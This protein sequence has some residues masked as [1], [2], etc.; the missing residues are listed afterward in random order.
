MTKPLYYDDGKPVYESNPYDKNN[1]DHALRGEWLHNMHWNRLSHRDPA[2]PLP[3][4][5][6]YE[7]NCVGMS[8]SYP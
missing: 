3:T 4:R 8:E 6:D 7:P 1:A 5:D 2:E